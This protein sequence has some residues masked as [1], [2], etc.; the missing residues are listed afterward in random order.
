MADG[1]E[2][3]ASLRNL[4]IWTVAVVAFAGVVLAIGN[5]LLDD[6]AEIAHTAHL[7]H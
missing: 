1:T 3:Y 4:L 2:R 6:P 5:W 7:L